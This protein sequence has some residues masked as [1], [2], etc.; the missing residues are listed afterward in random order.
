MSDILLKSMHFPSLDARYIVGDDDLS[1]AGAA[2]DAK[3]V[4]EF[5]DNTS[6][7]LQNT[8][9]LV[10]P[11]EPFYSQFERKAWSSGSFIP[12]TTRISIITPFT[13]DSE[14]YLKANSGYRFAMSV[15]GEVS[16]EMRLLA[17][18]GWMTENVLVPGVYYTVTIS[19]PNNSEIFLHEAVNV[20]GNLFDQNDI[21]E[22]ISDGKKV[23]KGGYVRATPKT[24]ESGIYIDCTDAISLFR[25]TFPKPIFVKAGSAI[26][27][28]ANGQG[29][30]AAN[31]R[32]F[33]G[34]Y[35]T[36][37]ISGVKT[38]YNDYFW[39]IDEDSYLYVVFRKVVDNQFAPAELTACVELYED[40][41][42][43]ND[44]YGVIRDIF[45][46]EMLET[47]NTVRGFMTEP[48]L[49]FP[50]VTDVH[51]DSTIR[52]VY[53]NFDQMIDNIR[54]FSRNV[55]CDFLLNLGDNTDG[56]TVEV[57]LRRNDYMLSRFTHIGLPYYHAIGNHDTNYTTSGGSSGNTKL[58][59]GETY[60]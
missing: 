6:S 17:D 11:F 4:G 13:V 25:I 22:R 5:R 56:D 50:L 26:R 21:W 37:Q 29:F 20:H 41:A 48:C 27:I 12:S 59:I 42:Y 39:N 8:S 38:R 32:N 60:R 30:Y 9:N 1:T 44:R 31:F 28:S 24:S 45:S 47:I 3:T 33:D 53:S 49:V 18:N 2:A 15:W 16:G 58:A 40:F 46:E 57:T 36:E 52:N 54:H 23:Y 55:H 43:R 51:H 10:N 35:L 7:K 19:K 14:I 34:T